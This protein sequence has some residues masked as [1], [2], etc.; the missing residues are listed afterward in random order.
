[1]TLFDLFDA[2]CIFNELL[3][4]LVPLAIIISFAIVGFSFKIFEG[5]LSKNSKDVPELSKW[6]FGASGVVCY[7]YIILA[8]MR[9]SVCTPTRYILLLSEREKLFLLSL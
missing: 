8:K 4:S 6:R 7:F 1:M 2:E 9:R 5:D 3:L